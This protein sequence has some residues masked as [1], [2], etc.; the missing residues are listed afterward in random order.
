MVKNDALK[1]PNAVWEYT[2]EQIHELNI[3]RK[4][5]VYFMRKY[6]TV[7][8]PTKGRVPFDLY[9]YQVEMV[10]A[11]HENRYT[12]ALL[13]RQM[14]KTITIAIYMLWYAMFH[15]DKGCLIAAHLN[16]HAMEIIDRIRYCYEELPMWLKPGVTSYTKHEIIFDNKSSVVSQATT[17]RTGRGLSIAKL[18]VDEFAF[19]SPS[20]QRKFWLSIS[21]TLSTGGSCVI[22]STPNGDTEMFAK[23]YRQAL[24][25]SGTLNWK[26]VEYKWDS[27]PDRDEKWAEQTKFTMSE[28]EWAQEH[29][30]QFV[31]SDPLLIDSLVLQSIQTRKPLLEREGFKFWIKQPDPTKSYFVAIDIATGVE[32]DYS[33]IQVIEVPTLKQVIEYR[34]NTVKTNELY[35]RMKSVLQFLTKPSMQHGVMKTA[36]VYWSFENN[37][38]GQSIDALYRND[39]SFPEAS[40]V[41]TKPGKHGIVTSDKSKLAACNDL[42]QLIEKMNGGQLINSEDL[43]NELKNFVVKGGGYAAKAGSTD[44]LIAALLVVMQMF[45]KYSSYEP[46]L[47]QTLYS[48]DKF[49][50][51]KDIILPDAIAQAKKDQFGEEPVPFIM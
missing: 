40:I 5:P 6:A 16:A 36:E 43:L 32:R 22:S 38:V 19:I 26:L 42:K 27:H 8:H 23:F 25:N 46:E 9:D 34:S 39:E 15:D 17:E 50:L 28:L 37:G 41:S 1:K 10:K 24:T 11:I 3:C 4:D 2:P 51:E 30:C 18:Y 47:H 35:A 48:H 21:P 44:D 13:S 7:Q 14:G 29:E 49:D 33:T 20:I 31:S 12:L 45:K